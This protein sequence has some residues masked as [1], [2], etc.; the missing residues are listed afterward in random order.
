MAT[1]KYMG[2][3]V[4]LERLTEQMR[5]QKSP[6]KDPEATARAVLVGRG[7]M[8][9][10]GGYTKKGTA[11]S[12]MTAEERAKDRASKRTGK[13]ASTFGY[14]PKTNMALRKKS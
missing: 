10:E 8:D 5:T 6:P 1:Q 3:G 9:S 4:L 14:N 11:R 7:M 13:P 2:K 12:N